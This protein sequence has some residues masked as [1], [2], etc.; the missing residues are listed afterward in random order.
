MNTKNIIKN[1]NFA[2]CLKKKPNWKLIK[3]NKLTVKL[4]DKTPSEN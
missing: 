3:Q 4:F 2:D 1:A